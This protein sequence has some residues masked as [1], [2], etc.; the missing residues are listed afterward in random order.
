M[1]NGTDTACEF[2]KKHGL[3]IGWGTGT[4]FDAKLAMAG[5]RN[6]YR[7]KR[8]P[9]EAGALAD[10]LT[11][12]GVPLANIQLLADP[13]SDLAVI[14]KDGQIYKNPLGAASNRSADRAKRKRRG[15]KNKKGYRRE[16]CNPSRILVRQEGLEPPTL[17][18]EGRCS[19]QLSYCRMNRSL[20]ETRVRSEPPDFAQTKILTDL[21]RTG[22]GL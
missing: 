7:G 11:V 17:G 13:G 16:V 14:M 3:K 15:L 9:I 6:P 2:T 1:S 21:Q 12:R 20:H 10:L 18:L 4:L 5:P 8:G 19:I 22:P